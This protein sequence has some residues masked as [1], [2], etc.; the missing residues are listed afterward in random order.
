MRLRHCQHIADF[1]RRLLLLSFL[2]LSSNLY[3]QIEDPFDPFDIPLDQLMDEKFDRHKN[4]SQLIEEAQLL[5]MDERPLAA[6]T[7]LLIALEKEPENYSVHKMLA[8]YYLIHVGHFRL[9]LKYIKQAKNLFQKQEGFPPYDELL[10]KRQHAHI[11]QL[12]AQ[13]RLN[14]DNYSGALE[15][16]DRYESYGYNESWYPGSRAWVLMKL[17][18]LKE[19]V[20]VAKTGVLSGAEPGRTLNILG[21]L[22]SMTGERS[23]SIRTFKEAFAYELSLGNMGQP[24]TPLNNSGE[25]YRETFQ[26]RKAENSWLKATSMRDGCEHVL[27]A[28]NLVLLYSEQLKFQEAKKAIDNFEA[29]VAQFPLRNGEEHRAFVH[30]ARGRIALHTGHITEALEHLRAALTKR[31]W[32]GKI[33]ASGDDLTVGASISLAQALKAENNYLDFKAADTFTAKVKISAV[34]L[35]NRIHIW[36]LLRRVRQVLTEDLK[37]IEDLF[38]RNTDSL[39]EYQ[40]LGYALAA[41]P[42]DVLEERIKKEF[43]R[44]KRDKSRCFYKAYQAENYLYH[45]YKKEGAEFLQEALRCLRDDLD[46]ALKLHLLL[47]RQSLLEDYSENYNNSLLEIYLLSPAALRNYGLRL[48]LAQGSQIPG[49]L[50]KLLDSAFSLTEAE[51]AEF[52]LSYKTQDDSYVLNFKSRSSFVSPISV[53]AKNFTELVNKL[54]DAVY[55][56]KL[57]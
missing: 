48:D 7:K 57:N 30:L 17:G 36:W 26:E 54:S 29:C 15:I 24:A 35:K 51:K 31:Q 14:L 33:G 55:R 32:F 53:S 46:A 20:E 27:P 16:L 13:I 3:A 43:K 52:I 25:V 5:F 28:L 39:I 22:L 2:S 11:L 47:L 40:S 4:A 8:G 41:F 12:L 21:I 44:D 1:L 42:V 45:G 49:E 38:I 18:R 50:K 37:G 6:R 23:A 9:A 10:L 56:S 19:A 34:K